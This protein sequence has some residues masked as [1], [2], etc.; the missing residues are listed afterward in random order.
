VWD[1]LFHWL[2]GRSGPRI[3][4]CGCEAW[5]R[6]FPSDGEEI[7]RD[8]VSR[9]GF[10]TAQTLNMTKPSYDFFPLPQLQILCPYFH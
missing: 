1:T 5:S 8:V 2:D 4:R 9:K 3:N 6:K 7:I 10:A